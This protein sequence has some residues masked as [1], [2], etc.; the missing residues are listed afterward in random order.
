MRKGGIPP[1]ANACQKKIRKIRG[2][3]ENPLPAMES[4]FLFRLASDSVG[5]SRFC[6]SVVEKA[7]TGFFNG[8][9][10]RIFAEV[11]PGNR[12]QRSQRTAEAH[13]AYGY[14]LKEIADFL[15]VHYATVSEAVGGRIKK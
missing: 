2:S 10:S 15:G 6:Q 13:I 7:G 12:Q 5:Q 11:S 1:A 8:L 9:F 3:K 14:T 4:G